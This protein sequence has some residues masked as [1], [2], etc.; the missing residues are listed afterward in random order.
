MTN[1]HT[2][3]DAVQV[4]FRQWTVFLPLKMKSEYCKNDCFLS[5]H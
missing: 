1:E 2:L 4:P 3:T 5:S